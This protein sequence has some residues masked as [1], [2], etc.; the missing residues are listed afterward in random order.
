MEIGSETILSSLRSFFKE[1]TLVCF[2][3][4]TVG[5]CTRSHDITISSE[6]ELFICK[7]GAIATVG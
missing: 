7:N 4:S 2:L 1:L 5:D 3:I 6:D